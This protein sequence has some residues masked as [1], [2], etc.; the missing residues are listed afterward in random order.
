MRHHLVAGRF[1]DV[2]RAV[3]GLGAHVQFRNLNTAAIG[4]GLRWHRLCPRFPIPWGHPGVDVGTQQEADRN[5]KRGS[6]LSQA[7]SLGLSGPVAPLAYGLGGEAQ[8][9]R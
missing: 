4:L 8:Q 2:G 9:T 7:P 6:Y 3:A 5:P 1:I